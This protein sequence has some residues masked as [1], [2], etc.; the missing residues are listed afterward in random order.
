MLH[1]S[2]RNLAEVHILDMTG[3]F[4]ANTE[5]V[6]WD[7]VQEAV[8]G[9]GA[10]KLILN[11]QEV[12]ECDSHGIS[13]LLRV[14]DSIKNLRGKLYLVNVNALVTKVLTITKVVDLLEIRED[15]QAA[16]AELSAASTQT[17]G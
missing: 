17:V 15:E 3:K 12:A 10:R 4:R 16:L 7:A 14:Y 5:R 8:V 2:H 11:F 6:F 13:E 9:G 1:I